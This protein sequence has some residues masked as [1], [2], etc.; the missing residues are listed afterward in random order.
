LT[1]GKG[2]LYYSLVDYDFQLKLEVVEGR[3]I[4]APWLGSEA[5]IFGQ[6]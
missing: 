1:D 2:H 6:E 3:V 5:I 4:A